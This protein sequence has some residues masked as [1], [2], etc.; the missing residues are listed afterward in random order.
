[1]ETE[2][3]DDDKDDEGQDNNYVPRGRLTRRCSRLARFGR[4]AGI[5]LELVCCWIAYSQLIPVEASSGLDGFVVF[6]LKSLATRTD[7]S[8]PRLRTRRD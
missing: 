3:E 6:H 4:G 2:D 7:L 5:G 1:V 8:M